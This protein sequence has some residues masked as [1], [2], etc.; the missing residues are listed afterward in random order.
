MIRP[1]P[2][3]TVL[4]FLLPALTMPLLL[5]LL[6]LTAL[7]LPSVDIAPAETEPKPTPEERIYIPFMTP[8]TVS[9]PQSTTRL[10]V[11]VGVAIKSDGAFGLMSRLKD[12]PETVLAVLADTILSVAEQLGPDTPISELRA[13]LPGKL[14]DAM[15]AKLEE[16][17]EDRA[18][19]EVLITG[20]AFGG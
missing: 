10:K 6:S 11:E 4:A 3:R 16:L 18:V 19:L 17:G 9:L 8:I 13:V 20:W 1:T 14:R 2:N 7:R 15:N 5:G 12:K